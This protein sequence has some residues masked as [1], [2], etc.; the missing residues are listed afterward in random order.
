MTDIIVI[1][2]IILIVSF[3]LRK[4]ILDRKR[5]VTCS[6]CPQTGNNDCKC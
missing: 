3:A 4:I 2:I 1:T 5:G 6:S